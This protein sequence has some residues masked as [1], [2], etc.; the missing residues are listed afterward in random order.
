MMNKR[1]SV[2]PALL[3]GVAVAPLP[4][5]AGTITNADL[6]DASWN[7][8]VCVDLN[9]CPVAPNNGG[10]HTASSPATKSTVTEVGIGLGVPSIQIN[11]ASYGPAGTA[12]AGY[13]R[14]DYFW[15][16]RGTPGTSVTVDFRAN[17]S[18]SSSHDPV[19]NYNGWGSV[20]LLLT[21]F[22][23]DNYVRVDGGSIFQSSGPW[24][25]PGYNPQSFTMSGSVPAIAGKTYSIE[26][27]ATANANFATTAS[28]FIDPFIFIDPSTPNAGNFSIQ[29]SPNIGN[30]P[31]TPVPEPSTWAMMIIGFLGLSFLAYR[32]KGSML[33]IAL[34]QV[35][36][37]DRQTAFGRSSCLCRDRPYQA[38]GQSTRSR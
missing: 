11:A 33:R 15:T 7:G 14:L 30:D 1:W 28:A 6:S 31:V 38:A 2:F 5:N 16:P 21:N 8:Y 10:T 36:L 29:T 4:A 35:L 34:S 17:G 18:V 20:E 32:R 9:P 13:E 19:E 23:I 3:L 26:I 25:S 24:L 12:A 27:I 37:G 22:G